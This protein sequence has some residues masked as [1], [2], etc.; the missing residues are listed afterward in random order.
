[1]SN[2]ELK[3]SWKKK[4]RWPQSGFGNGFLNNTK[5]MINEI[6]KKLD[7]TKL[8]TPTLLQTLL[9]EW[10]DKPQMGENNCNTYIWYRACT[11]NIQR[12]LKTVRRQTIQFLKRQ[13]DLNRHL[14]K[15]DT[16]MT[17]KHMK[18]WSMSQ[19]SAN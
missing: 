2:A 9:R 14:T 6:I 16:Q 10:K 4:S 1:M 13:K 5:A 7:F 12:I 3:K 19:G 17:N 15:Q 11:Y 18:R 8:R